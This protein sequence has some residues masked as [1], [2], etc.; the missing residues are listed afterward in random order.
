[1]YKFPN[2]PNLKNKREK[3]KFHMEWK[4]AGGCYNDQDKNRTSMNNS[5]QNIRNNQFNEQQDKN[6]KGVLPIPTGSRRPPAQFDGIRRDN[7]EINF[8]DKLNNQFKTKNNLGNNLTNS[9]SIKRFIPFNCPPKYHKRWN[10]PESYQIR[11]VK[12]PNIQIDNAKNVFEKYGLIEDMYVENIRNDSTALNSS[13]IYIKYSNNMSMKKLFSENKDQK[14]IRANNTYT[15]QLTIQYRDYLESKGSI[16]LETQSGNFQIVIYEVPIHMI[17]RLQQVLESYGKISDFNFEKNNQDLTN[18][19]VCVAFENENVVTKLFTKFKEQKLPVDKFYF[20]FALTRV[21]RDFISNKNENELDSDYGV[22]STQ[23]DDNVSEFSEFSTSNVISKSLI[24]SFH[25]KVLGLPL[26]KVDIIRSELES[27]GMIL[28]FNIENYITDEGEQSYHALVRFSENSTV[29]KVFDFNQNQKLKIDESRYKFELTNEYRSF[30]K[31]SLSKNN[32]VKVKNNSQNNNS[33]NNS[34]EK[35]YPNVEVKHLDEVKS[36]DKL[37]SFTTAGN[38]GLVQ[39]QNLIGSQKDFR[40]SG[41]LPRP[42]LLIRPSSNLIGPISE[43]IISHSNFPVALPSRSPPLIQ[44]NNHL[45]SRVPSSAAFSASTHLEAGFSNK[46]FAGAQIN[47]HNLPSNN[48][49]IKDSLKK[50]LTKYG[51]VKKLTVEKHLNNRYFTALIEFKEVSSAENMIQDKPI[52]TKLFEGKVY[53]YWYKYTGQFKQYFCFDSDDSSAN[54]DDF[55]A[56]NNYHLTIFNLQCN[57]IK[58]RQFLFDLVKSYGK[59]PEI[60]FTKYSKYDKVTFDMKA[61]YDAHLK[62]ENE[63]A[64]LC[65]LQ[66]KPYLKFQLLVK[67]IPEFDKYLKDKGIILPQPEN[68]N[69]MLYNN[70][71]ILLKHNVGQENI[72]KQLPSNQ[73][74]DEDSNV[75][76]KTKNG[77]K[78]TGP[79]LPSQ[80]NFEGDSHIWISPLPPDRK[81]L[82]QAVKRF[83]YPFGP[84]SSLVLKKFRPKGGSRFWRAQIKFD[85]DYSCDK[86]L[87]SKLKFVYKDIEYSPQMSSSFKLYTENPPELNQI[88]TLAVSTTI[89]KEKLLKDIDSFFGNSHVWI[90]VLPNKN[91]IKDIVNKVNEFAA[92]YGEVKIVFHKKVRTKSKKSFIRIHILFKKDIVAEMMLKL[93]PQFIYMGK[94]HNIAATNQYRN[95][96]RGQIDKLMDEENNENN[97]L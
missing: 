59:K 1:M 5:M 50:R 39:H 65:F 87:A 22:S 57:D 63:T 96:L 10:G 85:N 36:K 62:F 78:K 46:N 6:W 64:A 3:K 40:N 55:C 16:E 51:T 24:K 66:Q 89:A 8:N 27:F 60:M 72:D 34:I 42:T 97:A 74:K 86:L 20:S 83:I 70:N 52:I 90:R 61:F 47:V 44:H 35:D 69:D 2:N 48:A 30:I 88:G 28:K 77:W 26:S 31:A 38:S 49:E 92:Q 91:N 17:D 43:P 84:F 82:W 81:G 45:R 15:F 95:Y 13:H 37:N 29:E 14:I 73:Q 68:S 21:Y 58:Q 25:I 4:V 93:Q 32:N 9:N 54:E 75:M 11:V 19:K 7:K 71:N 23:D 76:V 18:T 12:V 41:A 53:K 67:P 80:T 94:T 79:S 33:S 56:K